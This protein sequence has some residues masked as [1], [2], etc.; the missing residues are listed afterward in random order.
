MD[1]LQLNTT[2]SQA[3]RLQTLCTNMVQQR[4]VNTAGCSHDCVDSS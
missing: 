4:V 3:V 2:C 1:M